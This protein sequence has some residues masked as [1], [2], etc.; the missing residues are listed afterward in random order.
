VLPQT[1]GGGPST[2]FLHATSL[3]ELA[4][5]LQQIGQPVYHVADA[6]V[7][8]ARRL[9][10]LDGWKIL[11]DK[12]Q[13]IRP[14]AFTVKRF[15]GTD[16]TEIDFTGASGFY[17]LWPLEGNGR[18]AA[19]PEYTL[20]YDAAKDHWLRADWY[21]L[22]FLARYDAGHHCP[23]QYDPETSRLAVPYDWR[24]PEIYE[25]ALV[26]ASGQLPTHHKGWLIYD[27]ISAELIDELRDKL[28]L[29]YEE[30]NDA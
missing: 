11:L 17:E 19:K 8:L 22:R 30:S 18:T 9:P 21:G 4:S 16:F 29:S 13:G 23:V 6:G 3:E 2:I 20:F 10:A 28:R 27:S 12:L 7:G 15:D 25:R 24:W 1:H 26:L 5:T 14:H